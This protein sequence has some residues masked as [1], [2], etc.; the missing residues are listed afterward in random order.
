MRTKNG[1]VH[2][3]ERLCL[4]EAPTAMVH[5]DLGIVNVGA[6]CDTSGCSSARSSAWAICGAHRR[7]HLSLQAHKRG[8]AWTTNQRSTA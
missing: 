6:C 4:R 1:H 7:W 5:N 8:D 2:K 3:G